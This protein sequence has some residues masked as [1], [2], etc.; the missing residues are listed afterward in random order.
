MLLVSNTD[1]IKCSPTWSVPWLG[2]N[3][4]PFRPVLESYCGTRSYGSQLGAEE[5]SEWHGREGR[6]V[7]VS[8]WGEVNSAAP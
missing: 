7:R 2:T 4:F 5:F 3:L 1:T 8:T 6:Y